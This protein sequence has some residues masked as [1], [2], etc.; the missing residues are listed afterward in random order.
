MPE[1]ARLEAALGQEVGTRATGSAWKRNDKEREKGKDPIVHHGVAVGTGTGKRRP[2][3]AMNRSVSASR[4]AARMTRI[5][6]S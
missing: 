4:I 1:S 6:R 2:C 5:R 3:V